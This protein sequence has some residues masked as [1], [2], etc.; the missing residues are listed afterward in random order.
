MSSNATLAVK[1][2][3]LDGPKVN[4]L[5]E[6]G[7]IPAVIHNHGKDS[8]HIVV[9]G[10]DF[11]K[12][13][14]EVG[15]QRPLTLTVDGKKYTALIKD[16]AKIPATERILHTVFEAV[17]ADE[18][19]QTEVPVHLTGDIPAERASLLV[20]KHLEQVTVEALPNDLLSS[21]EVDA[22]SLEEVGDKL[23]ASDIKLPNTVLLKTDPEAVIATVEM[24][25]DQIAEA[26]A[27][28]E[29]QETA[30][31][32]ADTSEGEGEAPEVSTDATE[33]E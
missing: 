18:R 26:D 29:E 5:R 8:I 3:E 14:S 4:R 1:K 25:K 11:E 30:E 9:T 13:Y 27:A 31:S 16:V 19:V 28:L 33:E 7:Q 20:L 17:R 22:S 32:S 23:H 2:R 12:A 21:V 24:P 15:K 6:D 10:K